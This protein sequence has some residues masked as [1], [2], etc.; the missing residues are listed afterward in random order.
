MRTA[1]RRQ[2]LVLEIRDRGVGVDAHEI[3]EI[4]ERLAQPPEIDASISRRMGLYV[5]A[6]LARRHDIRAELQNNQDLS[7]GVTATVRLSGEYVVQLTP[8]GPKP[9][10][11]ISPAADRDQVGDSGTH[12]GLAAA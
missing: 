12:V 7:G 4:N 5:V 8:D 6:Q 10:P 2:E 3:G 9:M 11:D 1:Y